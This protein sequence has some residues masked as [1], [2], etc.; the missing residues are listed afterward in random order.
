MSRCGSSSTER[1]RSTRNSRCTA[2]QQD[3]AEICRR[4]YGIPL[5]IELAASKVNVPRSR[6][7]LPGSNSNLSLLTGGSRD[8]PA[9]QRTMRDTIAWSYG[10]LAPDEQTLLRWLSPFVGGF[11]LEAAETPGSTAGVCHTIRSSTSFPRWWTAR[12]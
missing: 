8:L 5:A 11:T 7:L 9:R 3:L 6:R 1:A 2:H 4:L 12:L 10:L